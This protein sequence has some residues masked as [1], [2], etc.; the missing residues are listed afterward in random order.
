[1]S[2]IAHPNL[3]IKFI[4]S[5]RFHSHTHFSWIKERGKSLRIR[6]EGREG[7]IAMVR[8]VRGCV[9]SYDENTLSVVFSG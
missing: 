4:Q 5:N 7:R 8:S 1:M 3:R 2:E 9:T 6:R